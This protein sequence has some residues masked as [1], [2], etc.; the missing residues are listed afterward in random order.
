MGWLDKA[1]DKSKR[2]AKHLGQLRYGWGGRRQVTFVFGCQRSGTK[3][4]VRVLDESA[5]TRVYH[6]DDR[7][8]FEDFQ[9]RQ[10]GVLRALIA[11]SPAPSQVF[12]PICDSHEADRLLDRFEGSRA[13]WIWRD[14]D[15]VARSAVAKW[16]D[17]QRQVV[18]AVASGDL[19]TWGWR[20]A[21]LPPPLVEDL[22]RVHRPDLSAEEGALLFW[23]LRNRFFFEL[24]LDR[25]PRVLLL[26]YE[27]L[28]EDP[29]TFRAAFH[30]AGASFRR[31]HLHRVQPRRG[32]GPRLDASPEIRELCD[33]L[34]ARLRSRPCPAAPHASPVLLVINTLGTG[35]A[36][37]YVVTV[38]NW[39]AARGIEVAVASSGGELVADLD[40]RVP[41]LEA[42]LRRVRGDVVRATA[43]MRRILRELRPAVVVANSLIVSLLT[44]AAW[45][46]ERVPLVTVAHGWPEDRYPTVGRLIGVADRVVAVSPE[47]RRK[48]LAGGLR[49]GACEVIHNGVDQSDLGPREGDLRRQRRAEMGAADED[50]L[51]VTLGRLTEQKAHHHVVTIA[52]AL[53]DRLPRLRFALIGTGD[54]DEELA[55]LVADAGLSDRIRLL[56]LRDDAPDLLGSAD[57]YL[58][59]SDWEGMPLSTI[60]AMAAGLPIVATE[61]E[62]SAELLDGTCGLVVPVGDALGMAAAIARLAEDEGLRARMGG[63]ARDRARAHF[64]H[65]R[66]VEQ[67]AELLDRVVDP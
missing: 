64:S 32:P 13:L 44:R 3:M 8:A 23:L 49:A 1:L 55:R 27:D 60:E 15:A 19:E 43:A 45:P 31:A 36:E 61:T 9:L 34:V 56:G 25:D 52:A 59:C 41:H 47:V 50:L 26:R 57:L 16:G 39:L 10:D 42:P 63:A 51:V 62:G 38:A 33:A 67:L 21:R 17:H 5:T 7:A 4:L 28:L 29:A 53:R 30:H 14:P 54:R 58:N 48:L 18:D 6:E 20:T 40:E 2:E 35:G 11:S 37:R 65:D 46:G 12:K 66:M 22:R 24:G